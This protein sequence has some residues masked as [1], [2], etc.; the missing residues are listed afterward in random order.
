[1]ISDQR[2][3]NATNF[4]GMHY[5]AQLSVLWNALMK[6]T[7]TYVIVLHLKCNTLSVHKSS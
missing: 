5:V 6:C 3:V 7:H 4:K 1:M 2:C